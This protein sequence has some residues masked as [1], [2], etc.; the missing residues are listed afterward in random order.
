ML[1]GEGR[2][3]HFS[4]SQKLLRLLREK[5]AVI[6]SH[7]LP[8]APRRAVHGIVL[9][10]WPCPLQSAP[11]ALGPHVWLVLTRGQVKIA[12]YCYF[13]HLFSP[14]PLLVP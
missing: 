9:P 2:C 11:S 3:I 4:E 5:L 13:R 10:L 6:S 7:L 1:A 12:T 14:S 8:G